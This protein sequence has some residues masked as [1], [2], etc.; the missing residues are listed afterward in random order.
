MINQ[1][2]LDWKE[3]P[4][5]VNKAE[6]ILAYC[7]CENG[8]D[9]Y[10]LNC[11]NEDNKISLVKKLVI[12]ITKYINGKSESLDFREIDKSKGDMTAIKMYNSKKE[13]VG[14]AFDKLF[15]ELSQQRSGNSVAADIF[16]LR[17][18]ILSK[19][20]VWKQGYQF[21]QNY[22]ITLYRTLCQLWLVSVITLIANCVVPNPETSKIEYRTP[23]KLIKNS[24]IIHQ[25]QKMNQLFISG[26]IDKYIETSTDK[27]IIQESGSFFFLGESITLLGVLAGIGF[28]ITAFILVLVMIR[29]IIFGIFMYRRKIAG[30]F[31]IAAEYLK[32]ESALADNDID[33]EK[34]L[35]L[36][37]KF[38]S[39]SDSINFGQETVERQTIKE[40]IQQEKLDAE[41][42][43]GKDPQKNVGA[44]NYSSDMTQ[45]ILL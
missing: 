22:I 5:S 36:S 29:E 21:K 11:L 7:L 8:S 30:E 20:K 18:F 24:H 33:R 1:T 27:S 26:K 38:M 41:L 39:F 45:S 25:V 12:S 10:K 16:E 34:K 43:G 35:A 2:P 17:K 23:E 28:A 40:A 44:S 4:V 15:K 42:I 3:L 13:G 31:K 14:I 37:E 19:T 9:Y 32:L 6:D